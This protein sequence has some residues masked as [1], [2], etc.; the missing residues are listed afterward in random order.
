MSWFDRLRR[1]GKLGGV[2]F[3]A[4]A[5]S[6]CGFQPLYGRNDSGQ[7]TQDLLAKIRIQPLPDR[8]GQQLH[9]LLRD[10]L[11][12]RGQPR[13]ANY[14]LEIK[15]S[16][17]LENLGIRKDETAT[18]SNLTVFAD[19]VLSDAR[20]GKELFEG[21]SRSINSYNILESQF[22]TLFSESDARNRAL[23]EISDEISN[24]LAVYFARIAKK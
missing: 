24:R 14:N 20:S 11:N 17:T 13:E 10:R 18:R 1:A 23:R 12:P 8:V 16:E 15:I 21:R 22:A 7:R 3:L 9:N 4:L 2:L 6:G 5:V 19:F